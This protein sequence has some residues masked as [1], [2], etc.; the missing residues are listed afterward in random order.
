[1]ETPHAMAAPA[2]RLAIDL[3]AGSGRAMVGR[4]DP[5]G[6][7]LRET[8]RFHY[9][10][11]WAAGHL[12]WD[13]ERLLEGVRAGIRSAHSA[14]AEMGG[15]LESVGVDSWG[16]DYGLLDADGRLVE[17]PISYRDSRTTGIMDEVLARVPRQDVFARTGIQFL[18]FNTLYQ[19]VAHA[20]AGI[21]AS[22]VRLLLVP[23]LCHHMLCGSMASERTNAST[24]QLLGATDGRWE[25]TLFDRL[26]LPLR[27]MPDLVAAGTELG[28]LAPRHQKDL[29][30]GA[31]RVIAPATHDT[32]SAVVGTP[33]EPGWAYISS[34][35]WSLIGVERDAPLLTEAAAAANL[36]NEVGAFGTVR[37]LKNVM[38]LWILETCR[39]EWETGGHDAG[40]ALLDRVAAVETFPGVVFPDQPRFFNPRS[41]TAAVRASL[42]ETGQ[43]AP[44]EPALLAKV[45]LD[46]LALRYASVLATIEQATGREVPGIHVV[47]GGALNAYLNQATADAT[48]RPVLAGPAEATA[49]GNL[50]VQAIACGEA[51]SLAEARHLL[52]Q[53]VRPRRFTPRQPERWAEPA[54]RFREL[55]ARGIA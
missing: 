25:R 23:D 20:R 15:R 49:A 10:P 1:M 18:P 30:A 55:E 26:D 48:G 19:L 14:A 43:A 42:E 32:A 53:S 36:T 29:D 46:S 45:I 54:R 21:P 37:L 2:L 7:V 38:G 11:G 12:R 24:T 4:V 40:P 47:G 44:D 52:G 27:L 51:A 50:M 13:F 9:R 34:G 35:T 33:L 6:L 28:T 17:D 31:L 8:H 5:S 16:V 39:R 3:G 22:A 41:M